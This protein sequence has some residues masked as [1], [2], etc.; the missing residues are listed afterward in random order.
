[1]PGDD[2][3]GDRRRGTEHDDEQ[4]RLLGQPEDEDR[5]REPGD[6]RHRLQPGDERADRRCA[7]RASATRRCRSIPPITS[8]TAKPTIAR[9]M[10]WPT[11]RQKSALHVVPES[12]EDV[13][14]AGER[15]LGSPLAP[16]EEL[17]EREHDARSPT[18]FG[19]NAVHHLKATGGRATAVRPRGG[20][21]RRARARGCQSAWRRTS[22]RSC[23]VTSA[24]I[25]ATSGILD[26]ARTWHVDRELGDDP[27]GPARQQQDPVAEA[28][29]LADVVGDEHHRQCLGRRPPVRARRGGCRA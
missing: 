1:M 22:P 14:R 18:S 4:D 26:A 24:A 2:P 29:R 16:D 27:A 13:G 17:P 11:A 9:R 23:T 6:R 21:A 7:A 20:R 3:V 12:G 8:E 19:H 28:S 10:V 15:V 25:A 5:E